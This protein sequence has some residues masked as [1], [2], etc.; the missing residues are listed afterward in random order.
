MIDKVAM[1]KLTL[2][3]LGVDGGLIRVA[4]TTL[5]SF[6]AS[7][8]SSV[9]ALANADKPASLL[10]TLIGDLASPSRRKA[11]A[12]LISGFLLE[13]D[14]KGTLFPALSTLSTLP[15]LSLY[16]DY[17]DVQT[18]IADGLLPSL[19]E[20]SC[21]LTCTCTGCGAGLLLD[22]DVHFCPQCGD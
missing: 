16:G 11:S 22:E 6:L 20:L 21:A 7:K 14:P 2:R 18:F 19:H 4:S 17:P 5:D 3:G 10:A 9:S 1:A 12:A 8:G 15:I 13:H